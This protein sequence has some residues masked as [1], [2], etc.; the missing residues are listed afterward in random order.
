MLRGCDELDKKALDV[1]MEEMAK[2]IYAYSLARTRNS[3]DAQDLAQDILLAVY[4]SSVNL[5]DDR[6]FYGFMWAVAGNVYKHWC[7]KRKREVQI[8][9][10]TIS[11]W[12]AEENEDEELI[13]LLRRELA[14]LS[15]ACR[16]AA[17][18]YYVKHKTCEEISDALSTSTSTVKYLL[19]KTRQ[20]IK[21]GMNMERTYGKQSYNPR[22]LELQFWGN[23]S[24]KYADVCEGKIAQNILY[25]CYQDKLNAQQISLEIGVMHPYIEED[26]ERL[27][28]YGL[29]IKEGKKYTSNIIV[30]T[31]ELIQEIRRNTKNRVERAANII[32]TWIA[33]KEAQI[34]NAGFAGANMS[35]ETLS[36]QMS[37]MILYQAVVVRMLNEHQFILPQ[38]QV[39]TRC[40][41]WA[42]ERDG[43]AAYAVGVSNAQNS[44]GDYVQF[45]DFPAHGEM[46][47]R[48]CGSVRGAANLLLDIA[49]KR[50]GGFSE[51]DWA[52][53]AEMI[54]RGY[55]VS[56]HESVSVNAPVYTQAQY[57]QLLQ[58]LDEPIQG[59]QQ[60][61]GGI[62]EEIVRILK[63][64]IPH[65]LGKHK[66]DMA[67]VRLLEDGFSAV[68]EF[69]VRDRTLVAYH[70]GE[71]Q[72]TTYVVLKNV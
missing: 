41:I 37:C 56:E 7:R 72:S 20:I 34:R 47:H 8:T 66:Q 46:L 67:Y 45:I 53:V 33:E 5:K 4:E 70:K 15:K 43:G 25:A 28:E 64:Q 12:E 32:R 6:A 9:E 35:F 44:R 42:V 57:D 17:V 39:G 10:R 18:L 50:T 55:I 1:R 71:M 69:L 63:N 65:H 36:W 49:G 16:E 48:Y 13:A 30:F 11:V 22:E 59:V 2:T 62:V 31:E 3:Y 26:L 14:L 54:S 52:E 19:F 23:G 24:A 29:L 27:C 38:N 21:E 40:L 51:N 58:I 68:V 60:E 61:M